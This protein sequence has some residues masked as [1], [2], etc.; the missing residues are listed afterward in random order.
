MAYDP[1]RGQIVLFGGYDTSSLRQLLLDPV[2]GHY[3]REMNMRAG[4]G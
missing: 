2:M 1:V 4:L 3:A